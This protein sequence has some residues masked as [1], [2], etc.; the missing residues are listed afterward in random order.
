MVRTWA[1][2]LP[3]LV[4]SW[5]SETFIA[6]AR[7]S[8]KNIAI[9]DVFMMPPSSPFYYGASRVVTVAEAKGRG[10]RGDDVV[11]LQSLSKR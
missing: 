7:S 9:P 11:G 10:H 8:P 1:F 3:L 4:V 5:A 2:D 6:V